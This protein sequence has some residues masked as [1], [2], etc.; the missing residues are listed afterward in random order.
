MMTDA[1]DSIAGATKAKKLEGCSVLIVEDEYYLADDTRRALEDAGARVLGPFPRF[2]E[3]SEA[4]GTSPDCAVLD[5]NLGSGPDFTSARELQRHG[6]P[7]LF[8]TGYDH[9]IIPTELSGV[10]CL[11]KPTTGQ[12]IVEMV[13]TLCS[14]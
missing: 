12:K 3:T 1:T 11:Q 8:V 7:L 2:P 6:V 9:G 14:R 10:A 4:L 13:Q 5:I